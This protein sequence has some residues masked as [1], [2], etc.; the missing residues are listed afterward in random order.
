MY[1]GNMSY[2]MIPSVLL[3]SHTCIHACTHTLVQLLLRLVHMTNRHG[4]LYD[5]LRIG[6]G[7][8]NKADSDP[9]FSE[10]YIFYTNRKTLVKQTYQLPTNGKDFKEVNGQVW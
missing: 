3:N 9:V 4:I 5:V 2:S 10:T 1:L 8:V 6:D 7:T